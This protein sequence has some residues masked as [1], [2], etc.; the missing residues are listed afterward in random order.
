MRL[1]HEVALFELCTKQNA[2]SA[3]LNSSMKILFCVIKYY[4]QLLNLLICRTLS[5]HK[6]TPFG[7]QIWERSLS[8]YGVNIKSTNIYS[9][10]GT[11]K[12]TD[13]FFGR[14]QSFRFRDLT[15]C[16]LSIFVCFQR[17]RRTLPSAICPPFHRWPSFP[18]LLT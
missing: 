11:G 10:L 9:Q 14:E 17:T 13:V 8:I 4:L 6:R 15:I 18:Y 5:R 2:K 3:K 12:Q 1:C 7:K 16:A